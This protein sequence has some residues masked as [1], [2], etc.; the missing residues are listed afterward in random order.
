MTVNIPFLFAQATGAGN[1]P[2]LTDTVPDSTNINESPVD[3]ISQNS[4]IVEAKSIRIAKDQLDEQATYRATDSIV[5]DIAH[6]T[7]YLYG[8]AEI[9]YQQM[10]MWASRL[11]FNWDKNEV[12]A[13]GGQ[14]SLGQFQRVQFSDGNSEYAADSARYNFKSEKGKSFG[15]VTKELEG[16]LHADLIKAVNDSLFYARNAR[17]TTCDLDHPHFYVEVNKA[18]VM[19]DKLIVGKPANLVI[20]DVRTPLFLPFAI[21]PDIKS[22]GSGIVMPQYGDSRELGFFLTG[23]G[24][25]WHASD[26]IDLTTTADIYTLGSWAVN[27]S[28]NYKKLYKFYGSTSFRISQLRSGYLN[29]RRNPS[30]VK[31]PLD[32]GVTWQMNLDPKRLYNSSFNVNLNV[33]SSRRFQQ[34]NRQDAQSFLNSTFSSSI[35]YSKWWP[36]KPFR[37]SLNTG[38]V[39]NTQ[40]KQI[41]LTLPELNF[42]VSRINPFQKKI[43]RTVRKWYENIGF[44]YDFRASNR[45][46]TYDSIFFSRKTLETMQNGI[47]H[48]LPL[49]ANF[50]LFKY[51]NFNVNYN[52]NER[53]YFSTVERTFYDTFVKPDPSTGEFDTLLNYTDQQNIYKFKTERDFNLN[54]NFNT[55]LYGTFNFKKGKLKAIRHVFRPAINFNFQPDFSKPF[56]KYYKSVQDANGNEQLYSIFQNGIYG[57]PPSPGKVG[58]VGFSFGN[59]LEMKVYSKKDT[60][61]H[62]KRITLLDNLSV[63]TSYNFAADSLRLSPLTIRGATHLT[64]KLNMSF[65]VNMDPYAVDSNGRRYNTFYWKT[66]KRFYR[67]TN[68]N[69]SFNGSFRSKKTKNTGLGEEE[70]TQGLNLS[71]LNRNVYEQSYYNFNIPWSISYAYSLDWF[72]AKVNKRDTNIITQTLALGLDFNLTAKWKINVNSG[73]DLMRKTITRTDISVIR[74]MHCWQL[75]M[76]WTPT[77]YQQGFFISLYVKSQQFRF[78]RLQKQKAFFDSGF[79]GSGGSGFGGIVQ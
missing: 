60:V 40:T 70:M 55:N 28:I 71:P 2:V 10:H 24:Y 11:Q 23:L 52:Y 39:Q 32:F 3:S 25:Y 56:W 30:R 46:N 65:G 72:R 26:K 45:I 63:S 64:D 6:K 7:V 44:S 48:N 61:T 22:K 68:M 66:N 49:S 5:Y 9:K 36:N 31:P 34:V 19:K 37:L 8:K 17:Y 20:E 14:D 78:L 27:T 62:T 51:L 21:L 35:G 79:F 41:T 15:L 77:G 73:F 69:I 53:W 16:Y 57:G 54:V 58:S 74:D 18:K 12:F 50:S 75:E 59:T 13:F 42:N 76:K 29:E 1:I 33:I 4:T 67:L 43:T 38:L 47:A